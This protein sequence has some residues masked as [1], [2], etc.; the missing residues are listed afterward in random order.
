MSIF[1]IPVYKFARILVKVL[2]MATIT[3]S[4][5]LFYLVMDFLMLPWLAAGAILSVITCYRVNGLL[6]YYGKAIY[7]STSLVCMEI[8]IWY[9]ALWGDEDAAWEFERTRPS[10]ISVCEMALDMLREKRNALEECKG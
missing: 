9:N 3:L 6:W 10:M 1:L 5:C 4:I 8:G 2:L 7:D